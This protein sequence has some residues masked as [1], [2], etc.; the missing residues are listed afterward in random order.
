MFA[1]KGSSAIEQGGDVI[2]LLD[3]PAVRDANFPNEQASLQVAKNKFGKVGETELFFEG[4]FQRFREKK[5]TDIFTRPES[6][7][8]KPW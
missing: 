2:M 6:P 5:L 3:R 1:L 8:D 7:S 4:G